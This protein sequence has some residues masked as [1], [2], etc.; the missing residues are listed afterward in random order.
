MIVP[1]DCTV[2]FLNIWTPENIAVITLK[3]WTM[4]ICCRV[5]C[6]NNAD[7]MANSV[8]QW[9][10][11]DCFSIWVYTLLRL[12]CP[13]ILEHY[14]ML[15]LNSEGYL[16]LRHVF[17]LITKLWSQS[18]DFALSVLLTHV[19]YM[20]TNIYRVIVNGLRKT[21]CDVDVT[22]GVGCYCFQHLIM[23]KLFLYL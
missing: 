11:S 23:L 4:W 10:W 9:W 12:V 17:S 18:F 6:P 7:G 1:L 2:K 8:D 20:K 15:P 14:S 13:K 19:F 16:C 3:H 5:M 21:C 22:V